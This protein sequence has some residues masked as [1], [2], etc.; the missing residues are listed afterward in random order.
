MSVD[1][2]D[3]DFVTCASVRVSLLCDSVLIFIILCNNMCAGWPVG[4]QAIE[5]KYHIKDNNRKSIN[6][7]HIK[8]LRHTL[9]VFLVPAAALCGKF[10]DRLCNAPKS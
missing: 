7:S 8:T 10:V 3:F 1:V 2:F 4:P 5:I 6:H 9:Y